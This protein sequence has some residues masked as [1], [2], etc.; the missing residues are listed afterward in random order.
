MNSN[1]IMVRFEGGPVRWG[2]SL[3]DVGVSNRNHNFKL[4]IN[5]GL[6]DMR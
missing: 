4:K 2:P 6:I 5:K 3:K 1:S